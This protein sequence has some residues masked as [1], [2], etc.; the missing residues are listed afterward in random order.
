[1][2]FMITE[3]QR[4]LDYREQSKVKYDIF[5]EVDIWRWNI[6]KKMAKTYPTLERYFNLM[7]DIFENGM[8]SEKDLDRFYKTKTSKEKSIEIIKNRLIYKLISNSQDCKLKKRITNSEKIKSTYI[9]EDNFNF[10][11]GEYCEKAEKLTFVA[12]TKAQMEK[13]IIK[14]KIARLIL[15]RNNSSIIVSCFSAHKDSKEYSRDAF[16]NLMYYTSRAVEKLLTSS[17]TS[18]KNRDFYREAYAVANSCENSHKLS[19]QKTEKSILAEAKIISK[20]FDLYPVSLNQSVSKTF[21]C[22]D[23]D[24]LLVEAN[25][26]IVKV[27]SKNPVSGFISIR[28]TREKSSNSELTDSEV[29]SIVKDFSETNKFFETLSA[30]VRIEEDKVNSVSKP[31]IKLVSGEEIVTMYNVSSYKDNETLYD[32]Q[33]TRA[34]SGKKE[35]TLFNSCMR[36]ASTKPRIK[37]YAENDNFVKLLTLT[38]GDGKYL[39]ARAVVWFEESTGKHYVDRIF[40]NCD[41]SAE[42]LITH[43]NNTEN[44]FLV[45]TSG[46]SSGL[47]KDGKK[48]EKFLIEFNGVKSISENTPYFD[49]MRSNVYAK[50]GKMYIGHWNEIGYANPTDQKPGI[51]YAISRTFCNIPLVIKNDLSDRSKK[52]CS[53]CGKVINGEAVKVGENYICKKHITM[54]SDGEILAENGK[55]VHTLGENK[56]QKSYISNAISMSEIR[57]F[58]PSDV[59][60]VRKRQRILSNHGICTSLIDSIK[61]EATG[62]YSGYRVDIIATPAKLE[63]K[64]EASSILFE[65]RSKFDWLPDLT[66]IFEAKDCEFIYYDKTTIKMVDTGD[67]SLAVPI[68]MDEKQKELAK[69]FMKTIAILKAGK[70]EYSISEDKKQFI[71]ELAELASPGRSTDEEKDKELSKK[72]K[73]GPV[74]SFSN[75]L[76]RN[77]IIAV[78]VEGIVSRVKCMSITAF[79]P[80]DAK[81]WI[82]WIPLNSIEIS[83]TGAEKIYNELISKL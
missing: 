27:S 40:S 44:F 67:F 47:L 57:H 79:E 49:T 13:N 3:E 73:I 74:V 4:E 56:A 75:E 5:E 15:L 41:A 20:A 71:K 19:S 60:K 51:V 63:K 37:F 45:N 65:D 9:R 1:M 28:N 42:K 8:I 69:D 36:S 23:R 34:R 78:E 52:C 83:G 50:D 59:D 61:K 16:L 39:L 7:E 68:K 64:E 2:P 21:D 76:N 72:L 46:I 55:N 58:S 53:L 18:Q 35:G 10:F 24:R 17:T 11:S 54:A 26:K 25:T 48:L 70:Q 66:S 22:I 29:E 31:I 12:L 77:R 38:T 14:L 81:N 43:I 32:C 33:S 6:F 80:R 30:L 82:K 62:Y